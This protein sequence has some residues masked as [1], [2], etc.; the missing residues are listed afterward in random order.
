MKKYLLLP[1]VL[2]YALNVCAQTTYKYNFNNNLHDLSAV[3][4]DLQASCAASYNVESLPIG[5]SKNCFQ[6][7]KGCGLTFNDATGFLSGGG[8]TIEM[9][10]KLDT[11]QGYTKLVDYRGRTADDGFYN[12]SGKLVLYP[13]FNSDS[14]ISAGQ[15]YYIVLTRDAATKNMHIYVNN[16]SAGA[17]NDSGNDYVYGSN[18]SLIFFIDDSITNH[19]DVTGA[20]AM[21]HI[22]NY[23]MDSAT[24]HSNYTSLATTLNV[25]NTVISSN[26]VSVYPNPAMER[27]NVFVK[28]GSTYIM[29]D[30]SGKTIL[31]GNFKKGNNKLDLSNI[32]VGMYLLHIT[33]NITGEVHTFKLARE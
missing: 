3:G 17:Y 23:A 11:I 7:D 2:L 8:Y 15:Y 22:S 27:T 28:N 30:I 20:V 6:F 1:L 33:D 13:S 5:I 31:L 9:Y 12:Q 16:S 29:T 4:P 18:T 25:P 14:V 24:I 10:V 32:S 21:L 19:E 26:S